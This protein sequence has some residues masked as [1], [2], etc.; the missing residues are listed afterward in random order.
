M[1][2]KYDLF[3]SALKHLC[4]VHEVY[5]DSYGA[6]WVENQTNPE[7]YFCDYEDW[8]DGTEVRQ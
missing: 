5:L 1:T 7:R 8:K 3:I 2:K 6:I 4:E